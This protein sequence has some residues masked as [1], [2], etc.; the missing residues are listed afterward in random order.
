MIMFKKG[1]FIK[2]KS[3]TVLESGE[4]VNDWAGKIQEI[5]T[6]EKA[7]LI[8]FD[9]Q[10]IQ[11]LSDSFL[12]DGLNIG[13]DPFEYIF[14]FGDVELSERRDTD[15]QYKKALDLLNHRV[16]NLEDSLG[17]IYIKQQKKWIEAFQE[18]DI[19]KTQNEFQQENSN[20]VLSTFMSF[21]FN[22]GG[23]MPGQWTP[24]NVEEICLYFVPK[25]VVTDEETFEVYG[26][27]LIHFLNFIGG[28]NYI[29]N[30]KKLINKVQKIKGK[31]L[32]NSKDPR[33]FGMTKSLMHGQKG[34]LPLNDSGELDMGNLLQKLESLS[35]E[36]KSQKA[37]LK[38]L[39]PI[40]PNLFKRISRNEKITVKYT[41]GRIIEDIKF[42]KVEMDL[43][44]GKCEVV[45]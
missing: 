6:K 32:K 10:T 14:N 13:A 26:D 42:K 30:A 7:C 19:F 41:D 24:S 35:Q 4:I 17:D 20:F 1:D 2:V 36:E 22:Y 25:K 18:S 39:R 21:M 40:K 12:I 8:S 11:S 15:Q 9:T 5:F 33:F 43:K 31:I 37:K 16:M 23:V 29:D 44:S 38:P 34:R 28:Q 27:I 45:K 3:N